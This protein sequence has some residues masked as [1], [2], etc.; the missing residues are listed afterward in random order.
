M[1]LDHN[2]IPIAYISIGE[3]ED[4]RFYWND[5]WYDNPPEWLGKENP[6]WPGCYAVKYWYSEWKRIVF[7]YVEKIVSLGFKGLYLNK[8]DEFEYWSDSE[9]GEDIVLNETEAA[10]VFLFMNVFLEVFL[11]SVLGFV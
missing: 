4:Y 2:T 6:E 5:S 7:K 9:N 8:V 1:I 10:I 3:A 11:Y